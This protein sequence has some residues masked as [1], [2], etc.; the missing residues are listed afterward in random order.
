MSKKRLAR[1]IDL[2]AFCNRGL[3]FVL[4]EVERSVGAARV[5]G[6][7]G[8]G[9][10]RIRSWCEIPPAPLHLERVWV[11]D[12]NDYDRTVEQLLQVNDVANDPICER[13][14][15]HEDDRIP[16]RRRSTRWKAKLNRVGRAAR[17]WR[18]FERLLSPNVC[19]AGD[20][21]TTE[22][23]LPGSAALALN[24]GTSSAT[25]ARMVRKQVVR[26]CCIRCTPVHASNEAIACTASILGFQLAT[27]CL[28]PLSVNTSKTRSICSEICSSG[29][30]PA[31]PASLR[32]NV[33]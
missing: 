5:T 20:A 19:C 22:S 2:G 25:S 15:Q 10:A 28:W 30:E 1:W 31:I 14:V 6:R 18:E 11:T 27:S 32:R 23:A 9:P 17:L 21:G 24:P 8:V 16:A 33:V 29:F 26:A 13:G 4:D 3:E 12:A 7:H